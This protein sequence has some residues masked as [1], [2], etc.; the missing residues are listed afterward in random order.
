MITIEIKAPY[1]IFLGGEVG[2]VYAKTG[3]GIVDWRPELCKGQMNLVEN[4]LDLGLPNMNTV[5]Y[6]HLT[7]P[8]T[9]YV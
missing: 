7:L 1:L 8:T 4:G 6:T 2:R 5:S 3:S 9:P